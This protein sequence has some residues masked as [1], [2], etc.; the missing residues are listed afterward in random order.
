VALP[1]HELLPLV[2]GRLAAPIDPDAVPALKDLAPPFRQLEGAGSGNASYAVPVTWSASLLLSVR[3][4]LGAPEERPSA[5]V[6][7]EPR[8]RGAVAVADT[9]LALAAA[10]LYLGFDP[11]FTLSPDQLRAATR[12]LELQRPLVFRYATTTADLRDVLEAGEARLAW[13]P[14][15]VADG[16]G[17][18]VR[19]TVP[20]EG[21]IGDVEVLAQA[22]AAPD[23]GCAARFL[24]FVLT[25]RAQVAL[26]RAAGAAPVLPSACRVV[27]GR[28]CALLAA[29]QRLERVRLASSPTTPDGVSA[30]PAWTAAWREVTRP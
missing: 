19:A 7:F 26:A 11:P 4:A 14:A 27:R 10:A 28:L 15:S 13:G 17:G 5:R 1:L 21:A 20:G 24:R 25:R 18:Q 29:D 22:A 16:S 30:W 2:R 9:P 6:L 12:L 23:A 3:G 8:A